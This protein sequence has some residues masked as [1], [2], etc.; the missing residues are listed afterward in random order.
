MKNRPKKRPNQAL[1]RA[2][3]VVRGA[4]ATEDSDVA[5]AVFSAATSLSRANTDQLFAWVKSYPAKK[6]RI[7]PPRIANEYKSLWPNRKSIVILDNFESSLRWVTAILSEKTD[8]IEHYLSLL[9]EYERNMTSGYLEEALATID[10]IEEAT[11]V[12]IWGIESKIALL[13]RTHGLEE[14]KKYCDHI[15][16]QAPVSLPAFIAHYTS[17]RNEPGVSFARYSKKIERIIESQ[18]ITPEIQKY[19]T[20]RLLGL[21]GDEISVE[22]V[23]H[24][25]CVAGG[26]STLDAYEGLV[27]ACQTAIQKG[28]AQDYSSTII[29][30]LN[31]LNIDDW[32]IEKLLCYLGKDFSTLP[33]QCLDTELSLLQGNYLA[34]FE[35]IFEGHP[36]EPLEVNA[37]STAAYAAAYGDLEL[38]S[39]ASTGISIEIITLLAKI[40][41]KGDGVGRAADELIKLVLN[42]RSLRSM[43]AIY[44]YLVVEWGE[45]LQIGECEGTCIYL[46]NPMLNPFHWYVLRQDLA[47]ALL[48]A[49]DAKMPPVGPSSLAFAELYD[50]KLNP[51]RASR[52]I[53]LLFEARKSLM[54]GDLSRS[55]SLLQE[56]GDSDR[57]LW[58]RVSAKMEVH[59]LIA[60]NETRET[61][62]RVAHFCCENDELRHIVPLRPILH[63]VRWRQVRYLR[64][65]IEVPIV[66]DLYWRTIDENEHET[67]RRI[68][69]DEFLAAHDCRRPTDLRPIADRFQLEALRYFLRNVCVQ[70]VMDVS[71]DVYESSREIEEE[72]IAVCQWLS[73]LDPNGRTD[74]AEEIVMLTKLINVQDGLRDVDNSRIYVDSEAIERW[75]RKEVSESF[76]RYRLLVEAGVGFGSPSDIEAALKEFLGGDER[77]VDDFLVYPD[78]EA[79]ALLLE[80]VDG[81][82]NEFLNNPD[83]GLDAYLSMRIRHGSLAGHLRGP[84]EEQSLILTKNHRKDSY[85]EENVWIERFP[86]LTDERSASFLSALEEFSREYDSIIDELVQDRL[87]VRSATHP[88]GAFHVPIAENAIWLH[89]IRSR[90]RRDT[91]FDEFLS[92]VFSAIGESLKGVLKGIR[93]DI[94]VSVKSRMDDAFESLRVRLDQEI[95]PD[96]YAMVNSVLAD[97]V[98]EVQAAIDRIAAW[99]NLGESDQG[100]GVR[101]MDQIID[102]GIEATKRARRGFD[103]KVERTVPDIDISTSSL[104][105]EFT[106]ILFT[107]L[108]NVYAHSGNPVDPWVSV[109]IQARD[110]S[111][112]AVRDVTIRVESE[113]ED[114]AYNAEN[115]AR[116]ERIRER[117]G[118]L[119]YRRGVNL[120]GGTGLLKLQRLVALD[121]NQKLEFGFLREDRFFVEMQL[122]LFG[123]KQEAI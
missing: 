1:I 75:A 92:V 90:I 55:K 111:S 67:N 54:A 81:I 43:A 11:G 36:E 29:E 23:S 103:P 106:D 62:L 16:E 91:E 19:V 78:N 123:I 13:Q 42:L 115:V 89:W 116:V 64:E 77:A 73:E 117:M 53:G 33:I 3:N 27:W 46:S 97:V 71:F 14:Q 82:R 57:R 66:F 60:L 50:E 120:E 40:I 98:P 49:A 32:R 15:R 39:G 122:V 6:R 95:G 24:V 61:I 30:C 12:S 112:K 110:G 108:D 34:V 99:F 25:L 119:T 45:E 70:E 28:I 86:Y 38:P 4:L 22:D 68:A 48:E 94:F 88:D 44:G 35:K 9:S 74:Y 85:L 102:I 69:Y 100:S 105:S 18:P 83:F 96:E 87:Q 58:R 5:H 113:V 72:R 26:L 10:A 52:E 2:K 93:E 76:T 109:E 37:L 84:L 65:R 121:K 20:R 59:C 79:D 114:G 80:M 7:T 47:T 104:L 63:G 51:I 118:D 41:A 31:R 107:I 56:L 17:E 101:T 21:K 8:L